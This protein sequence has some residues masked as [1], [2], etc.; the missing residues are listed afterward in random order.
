M[1]WSAGRRSSS[2]A[3][4]VYL[5]VYDLVPNNW[6]HSLGLGLYHTGP[7]SIFIIFNFLNHVQQLFDK[8]NF[9][10]QTI[11]YFVCCALVQGLR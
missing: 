3:V 2:G 6:G 10:R 1:E 9:G 4:T 5:N 11:I 8:F 7:P